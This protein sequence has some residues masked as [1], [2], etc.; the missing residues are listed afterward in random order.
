MKQVAS[1]LPL[2]VKSGSL[3]PTI[4][5]PGHEVGEG[6]ADLHLLALPLLVG[7]LVAHHLE[8]GGADL[9]LLQAAGLHLDGGGGGGAAAR[10]R[11]QPE[12]MPRIKGTVK[13]FSLLKGGHSF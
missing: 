6:L 13:K 1:P 7:H 9:V 2:F 4:S 10:R 12:Q 8:L 5:G 11:R 3:P